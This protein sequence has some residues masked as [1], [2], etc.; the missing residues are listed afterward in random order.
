MT[1]AIDHAGD[2][3]LADL[4]LAALAD[5]SSADLAALQAVADEFLTAANCST[6]TADHLTRGG[7]PDLL[8]AAEY[9]AG[10]AFG[11][12]LLGSTPDAYAELR[13]A[14]Q[15]YTMMLALHAHHQH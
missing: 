11:V 14:A 9:V 10:A 8:A 7:C 1:S 13:V 12:G 2:A 5:P 15:S 4:V 3:S 6:A